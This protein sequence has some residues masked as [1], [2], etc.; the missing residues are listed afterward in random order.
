[1]DSMCIDLMQGTGLP[2]L[3]TVRKERVCHIPN[4]TIQQAKTV[5]YGRSGCALTTPIASRLF[6]K[7]ARWLKI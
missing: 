5:H 4:M 1:M 6:L 3:G 7:S 2:I